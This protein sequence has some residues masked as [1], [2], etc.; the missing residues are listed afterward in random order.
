MNNIAIDARFIDPKTMG[1]GRYSFELI[2]NLG[3]I[4]KENEELNKFDFHI[5]LPKRKFALLEDLNLPREMGLVEASEPWY[6]WSEQVAF[7]RKILSHGPNLVHFLQFNHPIFFPMPYIL[8]V[9][10]LTLHFFSGRTDS[11]LKTL[12]FK[13]TLKDGVKRAKKIITASEATKKDL[14]KYYGADPK[15]ITVIYHGADSSEQ[16]GSA[17]LEA[18]KSLDKIGVAEPY[19]LYV[20]QQRIHKNTDGLVAGFD[21]FKNK[22]P[23]AK[24]YKLILAGKKDEKAIWLAKALYKSNFQKDIVLTDFVSTLELKALY[25]H[26]K[27][28]IFPSLM[29]G[30]GIPPLEAMQN[31]V[32]VAASSTSCMPEVLGEAVIY[33]DPLKSEEIALAMHRLATEEALRADLIAKGHV[34]AAKYSW[35]I[36]AEETLKVYE[37]VVGGS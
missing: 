8:T 24:N 25:T 5:F 32:P 1:V 31:G 10:D 19:F 35:K 11:L 34:Q 4:L 18:F 22:Y 3:L 30:F 7:R 33:F 28:F 37:E 23:E 21:I 27:G 16:S 36:A 29:E 20:G 6:S 2:K 17:P 26:A 14:V 15:K 12:A 9:H 13:M